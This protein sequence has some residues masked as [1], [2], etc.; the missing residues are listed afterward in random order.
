MQCILS[1]SCVFLWIWS[2]NGRQ[3]HLFSMYVLV[4]GRKPAEWCSISMFHA[5]AIMFLCL[6][7]SPTW[8][9]VLVHELTLSTDDTACAIIYIP[10]SKWVTAKIRYIK[11]G[12]CTFISDKM[13]F[14]VITECLDYVSA[15]LSKTFSIRIQT[16]YLFCIFC[17][18]WC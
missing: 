8:Y 6:L 11:C 7:T 18:C 17:I 16:Y 1:S 14:E 13:S 12:I 9:V 15:F 4:S 10:L 3:L 5:G 2:C